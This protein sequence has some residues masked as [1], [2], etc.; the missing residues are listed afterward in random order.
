ML[1]GK[2]WKFFLAR[3]SAKRGQE[4]IQGHPGCFVGTQ[5]IRWLPPGICLLE[6]HSSELRVYSLFLPNCSSTGRSVRRRSLWLRQ[7]DA[8]L[9]RRTRSS[10]HPESSRKRGDWDSR[11]LSSQIYVEDINTDDQRQAGRLD[12]ADHGL[13]FRFELRPYLAQVSG[14]GTCRSRCQPRMTEP[15]GCY[16]ADRFSRRMGTSPPEP[17]KEKLAT[18]KRWKFRGPWLA[19]MP[20]RRVPEMAIQEHSAQATRVPPVLEE[21]DRGRHSEREGDCG[22]Q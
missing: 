16:K 7:R 6:V 10:Q 4:A 21:E 3:S 8:L 14:T 2:A 19:G 9:S 11:G 5:S 22:G 20:A 12:R 18:D 13:R 17:G 15:A 1:G